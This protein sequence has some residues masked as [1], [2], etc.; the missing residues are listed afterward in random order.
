MDYHQYLQLDQILD[1]QKPESAKHGKEAH[2]E[3]FFIIV[4][5]V[6]ELWFKQILHEIDSV[7]GILSG[8]HL[9]DREI[10][11]V[12]QR[13]HRITK[14]QRPL[15]DQIGILETMT[16]MD[17]LEFRSLFGGASGFQSVQFRL[18]ENKLGLRLRDKYG[19]TVYSD[20]L[21]AE[22]QEEVK[23]SETEPSLFDLVDR[24]LARMPFLDSSEFG[25]WE[26]YQTS[27][28]T[29]LDRQESEIKKT[30]GLEKEEIEAKMKNIESSR[31]AFSAIMD[32][33]AHAKL[34]EEG[35]IRLSFNALRSAVLIWL[36]REQPVF[37]LP[38]SLLSNVVNVDELFTNWRF[39]HA[40]MVFR[41]LGLKMGSGGS[42]GYEYLLKTTSRHK[43]FADL[44]NLATF[45]IP[46]SEMTELPKDFEKKLGFHYRGETA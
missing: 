38:Y 31:K 10:S 41:M 44:G 29:M 7:A 30:D 12:V 42:S 14:I 6:Y 27:V 13:L 3:H 32:E 46:R 15:N 37:H 21:R 40:Q 5:Q 45:L 35:N 39:R 11:K 23:K 8:D 19:Q 36:Y 25:F 20:K 43:I 18:V 26:N 1:A 16:P 33:S 34:V 28:K 17:F 4:H 22:F 24:W 9:D 2:D